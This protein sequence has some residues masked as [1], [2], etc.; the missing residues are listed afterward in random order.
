M[1]VRFVVV[2]A[3]LAGGAMGCG[4]AD[5]GDALAPALESSAHSLVTDNGR[6]IN[7]REINGR[8]VNGTA[9]GSKLVAVRYAGAQREGMSLPLSNVWLEGSTFHGLSGTQ[10]LSGKDFLQTRF[11]GVLQDGTILT[12]RIEDMIQGE[13]ANQDVWSYR[14]SYQ[15]TGDGQWYPICTNAD[16]SATGAIALE[17]R[18]DYREGVSGGGRKIYDANS[19][20]FACEGA[21]LA[22]CVRF[23]YAPWR[24]V[25]GVSLEDH[26]QACTR[27]VRA[28]FC[29]NGSSYTVNGNLI[30]LYD[31]LGVQSDTESWVGEAEWTAEGA[32]CFSSQT[33]ATTPIQCGERQVSTCARSFSTK[34]LLISETPVR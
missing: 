2:A 10:E 32:S 6:E 4:T 3:I 30:N 5:A 34:T 19:F 17:N 27:M 15:N 18:W 8:E 24:S 21:A 26:H 31:S 16:G 33:R 13:G 11:T 25:N 20:T 22:K 9:L 1:G 23:G 14:V 12:L 7:G 28:D 29:G